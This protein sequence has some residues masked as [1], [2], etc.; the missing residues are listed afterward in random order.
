[1]SAPAAS[2]ENQRFQFPTLLGLG[3]V[4]ILAGDTGPSLSCIRG[5][6]P[7]AECMAQA[8][9]KYMPQRILGWAFLPLLIGGLVSFALGVVQLVTNRR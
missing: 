1:M 4:R 5:G 6:T 7:L 9:V 2:A 8:D 3:I